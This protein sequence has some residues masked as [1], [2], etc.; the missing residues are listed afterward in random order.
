M[1]LLRPSPGLRAALR[2]VTGAQH[3]A[4]RNMCTFLG[5]PHLAGARGTHSP[6]GADWPEVRAHYCRK[7]NGLREEFQRANVLSK[8][9]ELR[10]PRAFTTFV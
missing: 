4:P 7:I 3:V 8:H 2:V 9:S 6:D 5:K 10:F 1:N